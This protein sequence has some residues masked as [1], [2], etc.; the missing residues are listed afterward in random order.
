MALNGKYS[1]KL[2]EFKDRLGRGVLTYTL[3]DGSI[4]EVG[5]MLENMEIRDGRSIIDAAI[6]MHEQ[7]NGKMTFLP[8]GSDN[9]DYQKTFTFQT[10][11]GDLE[12]DCGGVIFQLILA[13]G[14]ATDAIIA[15]VS[16][17]MS[18]EG[19]VSVALSF[20]K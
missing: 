3:R 5:S 16:D 20:E 19:I 2:E 11:S 12:S 1:A 9:F 15:E 10:R 4:V 8:N 14:G 6:P 13:M 7:P 17:S 18:K